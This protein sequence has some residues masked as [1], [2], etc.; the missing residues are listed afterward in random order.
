M[1]DPKEC[2]NGLT[3]VA[4]YEGFLP[5]KIIYLKGVNLHIAVQK[6]N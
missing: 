2:L 6:T 1:T 3:E 5:D 4:E